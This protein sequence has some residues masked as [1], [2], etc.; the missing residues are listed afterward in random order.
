MSKNLIPEALL[1]ATIGYDPLAAFVAG[2]TDTFPPHNIE[3]LDENRYRLTLAV[4]G[5]TRDEIGVSVHNGILLVHGFKVQTDEPRE[6]L[7]QGI[8]FRD[9]RREFK[10]GENVEVTGAALDNG[11]LAIDL[12]RIVPEA[13]KPRIIQIA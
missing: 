12:N 8:A 3:K 11:L 6:F 1:R 10:I 9:F 7:H 2:R 4:A 13:E 5:F